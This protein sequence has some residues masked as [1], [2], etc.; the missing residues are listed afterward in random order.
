MTMKVTMEQFIGV[1]YEELLD[2]NA[3]LRELVRGLLYCAHEAHGMC[4]RAPIGGG[5]PF[6]CCPIYDHKTCEYGCEKLMREL[7]VEVSDA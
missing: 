5:E 3:R 4:A 7:G 2:E 1:T 6:T